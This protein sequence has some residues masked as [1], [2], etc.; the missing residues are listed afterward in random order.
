MEPKVTQGS[1]EAGRDDLGDRELYELVSKIVN[2]P[3]EEFLPAIVELLGPPP[4]KQPL[5]LEGAIVIERKP[6]EA[7]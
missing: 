7:S 6:K 5:Q 2:L 3:T 1:K 4:V